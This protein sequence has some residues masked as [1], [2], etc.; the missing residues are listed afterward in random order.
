MDQVDLAPQRGEEP[1][2]H[3]IEV[4]HGEEGGQCF[5][6]RLKTAHL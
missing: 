2:V 6:I 1:W 3:R 4:D 5:E